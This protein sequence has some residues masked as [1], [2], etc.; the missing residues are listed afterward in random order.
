MQIQLLECYDTLKIVFVSSLRVVCQKY[1]NK[2]SNF[3]VNLSL[4][5]F[6]IQQKFSPHRV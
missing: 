5:K 2:Q 1:N 4:A 3:K 6:K